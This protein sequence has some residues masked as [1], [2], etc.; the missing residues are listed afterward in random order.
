M[1]FILGS[2][3]QRKR[4]LK[5]NA[6]YDSVEAFVLFVGHP[7]SGHTLV[8]AILDSHPEMIIANEFNLLE[9]FQDFTKDPN[10]D[11]YSRRLR[12]FAELHSTSKR[13]TVSGSRAPSCGRSYTYNI[14][15]SWQ[16]KYKN[17]LKVTI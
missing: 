2:I 6:E 12:I 1:A 7:R 16:G 5:H 4:D 9:K 13:Q 11:I 10:E 15:G 17:Q 14:P 8:A 3:V